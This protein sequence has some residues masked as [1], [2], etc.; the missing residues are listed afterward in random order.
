VTARLR[1]LPRPFQVMVAATVAVGA[2]SP[3]LMLLGSPGAPARPSV[4]WPLLGAGLIALQLRHSFAA[5]RGQW[6]RGGWWTLAAMAVL[7]YAPLPW[8]TWNWSAT[9]ILLMASAPMVARSRRLAA[10]LA[11]AP[12]VGTVLFF[13]VWYRPALVPGLA[14]LRYMLVEMGFFALSLPMGAAVVYGAALMARGASDLQ[15]A[16]TELAELAIAQ[17]RLRI[18][19]DLHDL[20]GQSLSAVSLRGDLALRLLP[21]DLPGARSEIANLTQTARAALHGIL[22]VTSDR[23][24]VDLGAEADGAR[25]LLAAA[26]IE[27]AVEIDPVAVPPGART[28]FAWALREGVT[29][30]LRHSEATACSITMSRGAH[31]A[32]R[33][34]IVNDGVRDGAT[35]A[36]PGN[37]LTGLA[38]RARSLGGQLTAGPLPAQRYRLRI[39]VPWEVP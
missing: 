23:P 14:A 30:L 20:I 26:G 10:A 29:N 5:A 12:T 16:H 37:G 32:A 6:P 34:E 24:A 25:A 22:T 4:T 38:E 15:A 7:V 9:Q 13:A 33:L 17:E 2:V 21:T 27:A 1:A 36:G 35:G 39:E 28:V 3:L 18:S 31:G 19:R 8:L 11:A